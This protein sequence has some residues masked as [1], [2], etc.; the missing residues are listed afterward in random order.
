MDGVLDI[1]D[2][3]PE[4]MAHFQSKT[5]LTFMPILI[6]IF[7]FFSYILLVSFS[8]LPSISL[9][10]LST[11]HCYGSQVPWWRWVWRAHGYGGC[12]REGEGEGGRERVCAE[13]MYLNVSHL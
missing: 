5:S 4:V 12:L 1:F 2:I 6:M 8:S 3:K 9:C 10:P 7:F 11:D 13:R